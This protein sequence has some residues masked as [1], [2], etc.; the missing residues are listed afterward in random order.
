MIKPIDILQSVQINKGIG[1][2]F[3]LSSVIFLNLPD[4]S[5]IDIIISN[6]LFIDY[7]INQY[8][9]LVSLINKNCQM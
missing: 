5:Y 3:P 2:I 1:L 9:D 4:S 6:S 8:G 7:K